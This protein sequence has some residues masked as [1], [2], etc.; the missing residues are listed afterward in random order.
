MPRIIPASVPLLP[1]TLSFVAGILCGVTGWGLFFC[2]AASVG[3]ISLF[4]LKQNYAAI[5]TCGFLLGCVEAYF[6]IPHEMNREL[7]A[8]NLVMEGVVKDVRE[9][10]SGQRIEILVDKAGSTPGNLS[11]CGKTEISVYIPGFNP[12]LRQYDRLLFNGKP[13]EVRAR[14][15]FEDELTFDDILLKKRIYLSLTLSPDSILGL[16]EGS[17]IGCRMMKIR[18]GI[19]Q[20]IMTSKLDVD[21]KLLL[22]A[23]ITGDNR[24]MPQEQYDNFRNAGIAHILAVSGLHVAIIAFWANLFLWPFTVLR[25]RAARLMAVILMIWLFTLL[26][27]APPSAV[28]AAIFS[29]VIMTGSVIQ[30][31]SSPFNSLCLAAIVIL[32]INPADLFA[33]GFQLSFAAVAGILLFASSLNPVPRRHAVAYYLV[34]I[35]TVSI[36]ATLGTAVI[37]LYYFHSFPLY[38]IISNILATFTL[39]IILGAEIVALLLSCLS[40]ELNA[41]NCI[42]DGLCSFLYNTSEGLSTLPGAYIDSIYVSALTVLLY[43]SSIILLRIVIAKGGKK[44]IAGF[45]TIS[46]IFVVCLVVDNSVK[47]VAGVYF[48]KNAHRTD[49]LVD[50]GVS[51]YLVLSSTSQADVKEEIKDNVT[52][53]TSDYMGRRD[54]DS[55]VFAEGVPSLIELPDGRKIKV[56]SGKET[57][58]GGIKCDYLLVCRGFRG[59]ITEVTTKWNPDTVILSSD[60]NPIRAARYRMESDR[61]VVD[62]RVHPF[63]ILISSNPRLK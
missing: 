22:V 58:G 51:P 1:V 53:R 12:E 2:I 45:L 14:H 34:S 37:T 39:P 63:Q 49:I 19:R 41:V 61:P 43:I 42:I 35:V 25:F 3:C 56:E 18:E 36:G 40:I 7:V 57:D 8:R 50:D 6:F 44:L 11:D 10:D 5:I 20:R 23:L 59:G 62:L 60:L 54:I 31:K 17:D 13:E 16:K 26:T 33:I 4:L 28:R 15:D 47:R 27:G 55:I 52:W 38:F 32:A 21:S 30:R 9:S 24:L 46:M 29:S 48:L